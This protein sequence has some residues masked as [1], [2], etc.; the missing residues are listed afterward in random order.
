MRGGGCVCAV[1]LWQTGFLLLTEEC[2]RIFQLNGTFTA[3]LSNVSSRSLASTK[4]S[5]P[6][7]GFRIPFPIY[8]IFLRYSMNWC[9]VFEILYEGKR[10]KYMLVSNWFWTVELILWFWLR[11]SICR[12]QNRVFRGCDFQNFELI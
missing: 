9:Y 12:R 8:T 11:H 5:H 4:H 6:S 1:L 10:I 2:G 3:F 7:V